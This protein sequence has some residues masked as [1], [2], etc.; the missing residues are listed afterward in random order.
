M[1]FNNYV[2]YLDWLYYSFFRYF[3]FMVLQL[4]NCNLMFSYILL[5]FR[6][7]ICTLLSASLIDEEV[8]EK[9]KYSVNNQIF[10]NL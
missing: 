2:I 3:F 6:N 5:L 8:Y 4:L 1:Q 7:F 10:M 9:F